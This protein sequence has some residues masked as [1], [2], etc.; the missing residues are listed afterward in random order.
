[1]FIPGW[2]LSQTLLVLEDKVRHVEA[3][4]GR[5][6]PAGET[7]TE[8]IRTIKDVIEESRNLINRV[9]LKYGIL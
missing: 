9:F 8:S 6:P 4:S 5:V 1:M 3:L 7:M 2:N